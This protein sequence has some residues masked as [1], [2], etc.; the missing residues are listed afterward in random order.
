ML[1]FCVPRL[2]S[3]PR[4]KF[5]WV[6]IGSPLGHLWVTLGHLGSPWI[7][8][9]KMSPG[10]P[11]MSTGKP[12]M[13]YFEPRIYPPLPTATHRYPPLPSCYPAATRLLPTH[14]GKFIGTHKANLQH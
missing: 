14:S 13:S 4:A 9:L 10:K 2:I 6:T 12:K 8:S 5:R 1:E 11:K 7:G 3:V